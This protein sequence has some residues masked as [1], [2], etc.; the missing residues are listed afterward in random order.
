MAW[1]GLSGPSRASTKLYDRSQSMTESRANA[2]VSRALD[3]Y[4]LGQPQRAIEE[5]NAA[6]RLNP[7]NSFA[8]YVQALAYTALGQDQEA[9][10][11]VARVQELGG[12]AASLRVAIEALKKQHQ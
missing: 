3:Y 7:E 5:T 2:Y 6:I 12:D 11:N 4:H 8:Y 10:L 9:E 1:A